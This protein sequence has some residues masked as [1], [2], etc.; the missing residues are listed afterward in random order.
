[1]PCI[2]RRN[3]I[4][5]KSR[6]TTSGRFASLPRE[7]L[8]VLALTRLAE[9][10]PNEEVVVAQERWMA[11]SQCPC[12]LN[13]DGQNGLERTSR[14]AHSRHGFDCPYACSAKPDLFNG[15]R[16]SSDLSQLHG[17][18][19]F[20]AKRLLVF[21][22]DCEEHRYG[23]RPFATRPPRARV[24]LFPGADRPRGRPLYAHRR[25]AGSFRCY[26]CPVPFSSARSSLE[27]EQVSSLPSSLLYTPIMQCMTR[28]FRRRA[29]LQRR[30]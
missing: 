12:S 27:N 5:G 14:R 3:V 29:W 16:H 28:R 6:A 11:S 15:F 1:M 19:G 18:C 21:L 17:Q 25:S 30:R 4:V 13:F 23:R 26:G 7:G 24:S 10:R 22:L 8:P 20:L 9:C 2:D